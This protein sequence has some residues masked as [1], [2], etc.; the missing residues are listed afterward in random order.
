VR[1]LFTVQPWT[2]HFH[3]M[4]PL[5]QALKAHGHEVV[6]ATGKSF[7]PNV[8]RS[9][10]DHFSCGRDCEGS[11]D[12]LT[13]LP[14]WPAI[15]AQVSHRGLQ[16]I[17]GFIQGFGPQMAADL[18]DLM[19]TWK[20]DVIVRDPVDFGGYIAAERFDIPYASIMWAL[21]ISPRW[22]CVEP[23]NMLRRQYG[24][25]EDPGLE[26]FDRYFVLSAL[27]SSWAVAN[28]PLVT[29]RFCMPPFDLSISGE[30]PAWVHTLPDRPTV[31]ATL[32]T[33]FNQRPD[34]FKALIAALGEEDFNTVITVGQSVDPS[35]FCPLPAHVKVERYIPQTL[36]LPRC[37]AIVFHVGF[38]SLH[39]A[40]WHG[41][42]M[43]IM[44]L[45]AGDQRPA[46]LQCAELGVGVMVD[47]EPPEPETIRAAIRSV[48]NDSAYRL[49]AQQLQQEIMELP[50]LSEAVQ[51]LERLAITR[52]PQMNPQVVTP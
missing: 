6:F 51:R 42:P 34:R 26:S 37:A 3:S 11:N 13:T 33:T 28:I 25:S 47:G 4:V 1:V 41:L 9:G 18:L 46:G 44:P 15:Q 2:G 52:E 39:S 50:S 24:P 27:P 7:G 31:Y 19:Q 40:L 43:V 30:L 5:A 14:E 49:R 16:Q 48:L 20:P 8:N 32:G 22:G 10:F 17:W 36:I 23:L 35:Q 21:Y 38:N 45:D 12:A 29:H